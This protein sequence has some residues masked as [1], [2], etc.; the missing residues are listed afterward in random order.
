MHNHLRRTEIALR[1]VVLAH[2][3]AVDI[4]FSISNREPMAFRYLAPF[5]G[6]DHRYGWRVEV[7]RKLE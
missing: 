2:S 6:V 3:C 5:F 7:P 4:L 1:R